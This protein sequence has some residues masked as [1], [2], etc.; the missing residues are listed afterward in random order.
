MGYFNLSPKLIQDNKMHI[1]YPVNISESNEETD[2]NSVHN[3]DDNTKTLDA[4]CGAIWINRMDGCQE[5]AGFIHNSDICSYA[6]RCPSFYNTLFMYKPDST[7]NEDGYK[8]NI[9]NYKFWS[10]GHMLSTYAY[11]SPHFTDRS[12][13][14]TARFISNES[15]R[16]K[17]LLYRLSS[18]VHIYDPLISSYYMDITEGSDRVKTFFYPSRLSAK[19]NIW[20]QMDDP[21]EDALR[22]NVDTMLKYLIDVDYEASRTDSYI[23]KLFDVSEDGCSKNYWWLPDSPSKISWYNANS[24]DVFP[25]YLTIESNGSALNERGSRSDYAQFLADHGADRICLNRLDSRNILSTTQDTA[26]DHS[27][28]DVVKN[29]PYSLISMGDLT[30]CQEELTPP[31]W[32]RFISVISNAITYAFLNRT[33][34]VKVYT[35]DSKWISVPYQDR[36]GYKK[37]AGYNV[38]IPDYGRGLYTA[39]YIAPLNVDHLVRQWNVRA[40]E[41]RADGHQQYRQNKVLFSGCPIM[42]YRSARSGIWR[43]YNSANMINSIR[44]DHDRQ[45]RKLTMQFEN[46]ADMMIDGVI[47]NKVIPAPPIVAEDE[48]DWVVDVKGTWDCIR[49]YYYYHELGTLHVTAEKILSNI[50]DEDAGSSWAPIWI[51]TVFTTDT[52]IGSGGKITFYK[53]WKKQPESTRTRV[54]SFNNK[55]NV[56]SYIGSGASFWKKPNYVAL[57]NRKAPSFDDAD[58]IY[59]TAD[60]TDDTDNANDTADTAAQNWWNNV[61]SYFVEGTPGFNKNYVTTYVD[62]NE[63]THVSSFIA[64]V[65]ECDPSGTNC[66]ISSATKKDETKGWILESPDHGLSDSFPFEHDESCKVTRIKSEDGKNVYKF[67][68]MLQDKTDPTK[69]VKTVLCE[70]KW[71]YDPTIAPDNVG[72]YQPKNNRFEEDR[73][74]QYMPAMLSDYISN[75]SDK[76]VK[77]KTTGE[78]IKVSDLY[79]GRR[80]NCLLFRAANFHSVKLYNTNK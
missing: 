7:I 57:T 58:V 53:T 42:S 46:T 69:F 40:V 4:A 64:Y 43:L 11:R 51:C 66:L 62:T 50:G 68:V 23:W 35:S 10:Y 21:K 60:D 26:Q 59:Y 55:D 63:K 73:I 71:E 45:N 19:Y 49:G 14:E 29:H 61:D 12:L 47:P 27:F 38:T 28:D 76:Y 5:D 22:V 34:Y 52:S 37:G 72:V 24:V 65:Y 67:Y 41:S 31:R 17:T 16:G 2:I 36:M 54:T 39:K 80:Y 79:T 1:V 56:R 48:M 30:S 6:Y 33:K 32:S 18:D 9:A 77:T 20:P 13:S 44:W 70:D 78:F 8:A 25:S 75:F 15:I 3:L 74:G